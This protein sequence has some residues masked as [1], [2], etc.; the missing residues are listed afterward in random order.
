MVTEPDGSA[1]SNIPD[2]ASRTDWTMSC[3]VAVLSVGSENCNS[4]TLGTRRVLSV[5]Y[6]ACVFETKSWG[7]RCCAWELG[8]VGDRSSCK[9]CIGLFIGHALDKTGPGVGAAKREG[10]VNVRGGV[11]GASRGAGVNKSM[12]VIRSPEGVAAIHGKRPMLARC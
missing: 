5:R 12:F 11:R 10:T 2:K 1:T 3:V 4:C 7:N 8:E 9:W 6:S